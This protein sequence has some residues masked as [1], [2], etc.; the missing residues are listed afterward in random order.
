MLL[1][2]LLVIASATDYGY[3]YTPTPQAKPEDKRNVLPNK[4]DHEEKDKF[5]PYK[6]PGDDIE[7][8]PYYGQEPKPEGKEKL[9]D[10]PNIFEV[11]GLVLCKSGTKYFPLEGEF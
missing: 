2:S 5:S 11:Q 8:K 6:K 4:P 9:V 10:L 3:T 7:T 1:L